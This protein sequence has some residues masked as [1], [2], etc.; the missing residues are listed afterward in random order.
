MDMSIKVCS[1]CN[2][3]NKGIAIQKEIVLKHIVARDMHGWKPLFE[4]FNSLRLKTKKMSDW[5]A[6]RPNKKDKFDSGKHS[7]STSTAF[8]TDYFICSAGVLNKSSKDEEHNS[9][10]PGSTCNFKF[11]DDKMVIFNSY[12]NFL[13]LEWQINVESIT[14]NTTF[15]EQDL[16]VEVAT[17]GFRK[18]FCVF[19]K[20]SV[21]DMKLI[22]YEHPDSAVIIPKLLKI[23][24][25]PV[26]PKV[27]D[28]KADVR[29]NGKQKNKPRIS[30][31]RDV[32]F[33]DFEGPQLM[34]EK[35]GRKRLQKLKEGSAASNLHSQTVSVERGQADSSE[36]N[37]QQCNSS[38][39]TSSGKTRKIVIPVAFAQSYKTSGNES[40]WALHFVLPNAFYKEIFQKMQPIHSACIFYVG[41][42]TVTCVL[43]NSASSVTDGESV[44]AEE[45]DYA[46]VESKNCIRMKMEKIV[47]G[48]VENEICADR[49]KKV[50]MKKNET[51]SKSEV[52]PIPSEMD[53][54]NAVPPFLKKVSTKCKVKAQKMTDEDSENNNGIH[55]QTENDEHDDHHDRID[56]PE[57]TG[58]HADDRVDKSDDIEEGTLASF[59]CNADVIRSLRRII[60]N[61][62]V[63]SRIR[64]G[65]TEQRNLLINIPCGLHSCWV[66]LKNG[67]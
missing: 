34:T 9:R 57:K 60:Q 58:E 26:T 43:R 38:I 10:F 62:G 23:T 3:Q 2:R 28:D 32:S 63:H 27:R 64:I 48:N 66:F 55:G 45:N 50:K 4:T 35:K 29:Q 51:P 12:G 33:D 59:V 7:F 25:I 1:L 21:I 14:E 13:I 15:P 42:T 37:Q 53:P 6:V 19:R 31:K 65:L 20:H 56:K 18:L 44:G 49:P 52:T 17:D 61:V 54:F 67:E 30:A 22:S 41:R 24:M 5:F 47:I 39:Q 16:N 40:H 8:S 46:S 11:C 36:K